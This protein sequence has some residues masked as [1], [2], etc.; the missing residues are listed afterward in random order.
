MSDL[1]PLISEAMASIKGPTDAR[2]SISDGSGPMSMW[3]SPRPAALVR[4]GS[5]AT[6]CAS[7]RK[8]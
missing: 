3:T 8:W 1:D 6:H 2:P 5:W 4:M 7:D